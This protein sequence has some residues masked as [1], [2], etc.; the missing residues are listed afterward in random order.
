MMPV[1]I[2]WAT[3]RPKNRKAMK[4]KKAAQ[5]TAACG[6]STRVETIGG[7]RVGRVVQAVEEVEHQGDGD[8]ADEHASGGGIHAVVSAPLRR[9]R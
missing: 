7:D 2:V 9:A 5:N 6:G 8:Q 4:L 1:P 3:C